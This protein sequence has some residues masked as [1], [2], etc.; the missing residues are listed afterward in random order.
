MH[1]RL[2][3]VLGVTGKPVAKSS[4]LGPQVGEDPFSKLRQE[5]R[6]RVKEQQQRQL[7]NIKAS[8]KAVGSSAALPPTLKLAAA[9]PAHGKGKPTKR[10]EMQDDV[11]TALLLQMKHHSRWFSAAVSMCLALA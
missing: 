4:L 6:E 2:Q 1:K 8:A 9:L 5:K 10:K 3:L 7:K 11:R